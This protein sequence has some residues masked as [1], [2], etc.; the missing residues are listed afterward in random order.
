MK[1]MF[2]MFPALVMAF[3]SFV[4]AASADTG[5]NEDFKRDFSKKQREIRLE[6]LNETDV[7][8]YLRADSNTGYNNIVENDKDDPTLET[9]NAYSD[10]WADTTANKNETAAA[11]FN[12][13]KERGDVHVTSRNKV[14]L[15][16][17]LSAKANS[18]FNTIEHNSGEVHVKTGNATAANSVINMV[19]SNVTKI[20]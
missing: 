2:L 10:N 12:D 20:Q 3:A 1:K 11:S 9:G 18:G 5:S 17:D 13:G 16:N 19:N 7:H 15:K 14:N 8:N 4:T 6:S